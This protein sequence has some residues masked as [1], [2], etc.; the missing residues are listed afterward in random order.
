MGLGIL[1]GKRK[2]PHDVVLSV[3]PGQLPALVGESWGAMLALAYA[4]EPPENT[5]PIVPVGCGTFDKQSREVGAKIREER[6]VEYIAKHPQHA[7]DLDLKLNDRIMKWHEMTDYFRSVSSASKSGAE[8]SSAQVACRQI[9][10]K[11]ILNKRIT[12]S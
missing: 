12:G 8:P 6:I 4:A 10:V 11:K 1:C 5:G 2:H 7:G 9:Q 3:R